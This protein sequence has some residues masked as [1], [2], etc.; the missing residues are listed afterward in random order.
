MN[1]Y[2]LDSHIFLWWISNSDK[3]HK[4]IY[5]II[6]DNENQIYI[7]SA[8]IWEIAIKEALGKIEIDYDIILAIEECGFIELQIS[9]TCAN[10]TKK[11]P[12]IHKDPFDRMLISQAIEKDMTLISVDGFIK[13]YNN[14]KVIS[15][16]K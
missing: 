14:V 9:A 4:K 6:A 16:K 5:N 15:L 10:A 1:K 3:L 7:S 13:K 11:L 2:L 8:T 12:P